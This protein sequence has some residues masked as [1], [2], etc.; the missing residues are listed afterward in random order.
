MLEVTSEG[1]QLLK[2][3]GVR[4]KKGRGRGGLA[5]QFWCA[6]IS[7]WA[8]GLGLDPTVEDESSGAR[9]DVVIRVEDQEP[10]AVEVELTPGHEVINVS[11]DLESGF[12]TVVSLIEDAARVDTV[13]AA[14]RDHIGTPDPGATE[15]LVVHLRDFRTVLGRLFE[16]PEAG[17]IVL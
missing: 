5:H 1:E 14:V 6:S 13:L 3:F 10:I 7:D 15:V 9:V 8:T 12:S 2:S 4:I 11:K 16:P 17:R